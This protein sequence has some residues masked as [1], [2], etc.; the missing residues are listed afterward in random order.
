MRKITISIIVAIFLAMPLFGR[1]RMKKELGVAE[2]SKN[3]QTIEMIVDRFGWT[4]EIFVVQKDLP[5]RWKIDGKELNSCNEKIVSKEL[6]FSFNL[7]EG[8]QTKKIKP[9]K[10][11][12]Y[13]FSCWM[14]MIP[15]KII[16][17]DDLQKTDIKKLNKT[18]IVE[19]ITSGH[20]GSQKKYKKNE[21]CET[22]NC[23]ETAPNHNC[24]EK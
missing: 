3:Y 15:G 8:R 10:A 22:E 23:D 16:V 13:Q 20:C 18:A 7:R 21:S 11:G 24:E 12:E 14:K 4:P 6:D 5:I 1:S 2:I 17:V 19:P 9:T